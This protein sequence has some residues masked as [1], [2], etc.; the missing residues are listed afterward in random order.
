MPA[1]MGEKDIEIGQ[2]PEFGGTFLIY[3]RLN[4]VE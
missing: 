1:E 4:F 2:N 3:W